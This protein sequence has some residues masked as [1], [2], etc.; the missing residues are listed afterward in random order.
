MIELHTFSIVARDPHT[1]DFGVAVSTARPNV[2]SLAPFASRRGA[3]ATQARVNTDLGRR[4]LLALDGGLGIRAALSAL[5]E[6]DLDRELRQL[7][8]VDA[9]E[10]FAYTGAECVPWC[11]H[12]SGSGFTVAGNM[13]TGPEVIRAMADAFTAAGE[14]KRELSER[15]LMA[16]EAGQAAGG[17]KRG[18]QSAALLVTSDEP[19]MYHNLRVDEHAD[20]VAELRRIYGVVV[21]H[22]EQ[23]AQQYGP[24]GLRLFGRVKY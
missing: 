21:A 4:G 3:I 17:D 14:E 16:L 18:R 23:I 15:L 24:D 22:T 7:H 1:G 11:G 8:G 19:R 13:L 5:L 2:G 6:E 9:K 10:T 20:P 12:E